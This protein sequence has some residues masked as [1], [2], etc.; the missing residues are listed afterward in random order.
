MS[1]IMTSKIL[2]QEYWTS[3]ASLLRSHVAMHSI[4]RPDAPLRIISGS[5]AALEVLGPWGKLSVLAPAASGMGA[6]EFRPEAG[7]LG[8]EY[9]SFFFTEDGLVRFEGLDGVLDIEAAVEY[10]LERVSKMDLPSRA[11]PNAAEEPRV[12]PANRE[13]LRFA[14]D[15]NSTLRAFS[16]Q[17]PNKVCR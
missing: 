5:D 13:V 10:L 11:E 3:L 14:Q 4:A 2:T 1:A 17:A 6:T 16:K 15:D 7:E 9:S 8:D 12:L